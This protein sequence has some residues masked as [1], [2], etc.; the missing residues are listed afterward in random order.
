MDTASGLRS[1]VVSM[2]LKRTGYSFEIHRVSQE[3]L[4]GLYGSISEHHNLFNSMYPRIL[5][6]FPLRWLLFYP[7][8]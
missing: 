5:K 6:R 4:D 7:S 1:P 2:S 8:R 3:G